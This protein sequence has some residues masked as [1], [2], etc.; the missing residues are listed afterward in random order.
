MIIKSV[1]NIKTFIKVLNLG[2]QF[3]KYCKSYITSEI[4]INVFKFFLYILRIANNLLQLFSYIIYLN[5]K[6]NVINY[7][8]RTKNKNLNC[9]LFNK[10]NN[11]LRNFDLY[12][13][14]SYNTTESLLLLLKILKYFHNSLCQTIKT[15]KIISLKNQFLK[16]KIK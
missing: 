7:V 16:S 6:S 10:Y 2:V 3:V 15:C 4:K 8:N 1:T 12:F 13:K 11:C 14:I 5:F 9:V